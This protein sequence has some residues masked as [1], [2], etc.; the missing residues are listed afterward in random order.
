MSVPLDE[1]VATYRS[2]AQDEFEARVRDPHLL[3]LR[4]PSP[5]S[6]ERAEFS[7]L[8]LRSANGQAPQRP[9]LIPV[10]KRPG[11]N[12]FGMMV[13]IGRAANNDIVLNDPAM[14]KLQCYLHRFAGTWAVCDPGSTNG[15][16]LDGARVR[17]ASSTL[18]S[19]S[20]LG[21]ADVYE[22]MFLEP[23]ALWALVQGGDAV[24]PARAPGAAAS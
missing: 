13:T 9:V 15:T 4:A 16:F 18:R 19:G 20:R 7:T 10:R 5:T 17:S 12:P 23:R 14:S 11:G 8:L 3:M 24:E 21:L 6:P 2:C 22:V 1:F